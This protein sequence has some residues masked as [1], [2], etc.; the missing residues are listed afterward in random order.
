MARRLIFGC[1]YLG[2]RVG[3]RWLDA[4]D[5]VVAATRSGARA[6]R[7]AEAG[8]EPLVAD[9]A[10][11]DSLEA[12][13]HVDSVLF[14]V[15]FDRSSDASIEEVYA[16]GLRSVID[17]LQEGAGRIIY[18][19]STGVYGDAGGD[20]VDE[21]TPPDPQ[22]AGGKASLAAEQVLCGSRFADR[23]AVL[24]L[25]GIYGPDRLPYLDKLKAGEPIAAPQDGW[26]NLT[27]VDDAADVVV[28]A[29][30]ADSAPGTLCV[31]DGNP[32]QRSDYYTELARLLDAPP[33]SF[34]EP[35]PGS[36]RAARA[37]SDKRVSNAKLLATLPVELQYPT[38][39]A[40]LAS[41]VRVAE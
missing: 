33:P 22:R 34:T 4:G 23:S 16:G 2:K 31:S 30:A 5:T 1:G 29:A 20:W 7:L 35:E 15:G 37:A 36:P 32:P 24:R 3:E 14:A 6:A 12:L 40:G 9:V 11:P 13:P 38:Y 8:Y 39:R 18:I 26:L 28:A 25:A 17:R 10:K 21:Q 41:I 27:H 19:S